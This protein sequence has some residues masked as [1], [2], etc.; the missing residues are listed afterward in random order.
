MIAELRAGFLLFVSL[1]FFL[2]II[3]LFARSMVI[4]P[5]RQSEHARL[6]TEVRSTEHSDLSVSV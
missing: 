2:I 3:A 4:R 5:D 6:A 1:L